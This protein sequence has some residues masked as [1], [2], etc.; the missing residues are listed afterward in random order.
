[1]S[2]PAADHPTDTEIRLRRRAL[3]LPALAFA[4]LLVLLVT[5]A[6]AQAAPS[7]QPAAELLHHLHEALAP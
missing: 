5:G 2:V 1:M 3:V 6:D 7:L 4:A